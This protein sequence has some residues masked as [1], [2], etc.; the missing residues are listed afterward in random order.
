METLFPIPSVKP[1]PLERY[2]R[3][4]DQARRVYEVLPDDGRAEANYL[5]LEGA[6]RDIELQ[7][8]AR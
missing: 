3:E 1:P 2:R 8:I 4:L 7:E 5:R 6:V